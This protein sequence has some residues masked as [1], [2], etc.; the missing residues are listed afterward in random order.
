MFLCPVALRPARSR[1]DFDAPTKSARFV[2]P[3]LQ[4]PDLPHD[5]H[6][7]QL[8]QARR[9]IVVI[10]GVQNVQPVLTHPQHPGDQCVAAA[11]QPVVAHRPAIPVCP[12]SSH[13][14]GQPFLALQCEVLQSTAQRLSDQFAPVQ[15]AHRRQHMSGIRP[16]PSPPLDQPGLRQPLH[17]QRQEPVRAVAFGHPATEIRSGQ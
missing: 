3:V 11:G 15:T 7:P 1:V 4:D 16:D 14:S 13:E 6:G 9:G 10:D 17:H 12:V 5:L 8:P 2:V